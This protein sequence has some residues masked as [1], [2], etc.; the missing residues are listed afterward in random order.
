MQPDTSRADSH[1]WAGNY[2]YTASQI[3][4]PKTVEE[5]QA[6]VVESRSLRALGSR[7]SF[8]DVADNSD[9]LISLRH[10]DQIHA[11][12]T[13]RKTVTVGAGVTYGQL[14][15][16][17]DQHGFALHNLA[18]LPHI[19]VVGACMTATH[20]SGERNGNLATAV[21]GLE[22]VAADGRLVHLTR[23]QN[24]A[25]LDGLI[26]G[27]GA[28][29]IITKITLEVQPRFDMTQTIYLNL[30][31]EQA[32]AHF[33]AIQAS[34][35]S[36]SLFTQWQNAQFEQVW[37]KRLADANPAPATATGLFGA[38]PSGSPM[39]PV[40]DVDPT[41]CTGQL[42]VVGTWYERLPHFR[43]EFTPSHGAELQSEFFVPRAKAGEA[44]EAVSKLG[45]LIAPLLYISEIRTIAADQLWLSPCYQRDSV[46]IH[47]TWKPL[48][49]EV[50]QVLPQIEKILMPF[51]ARPHWGKL[52]LLPA[53]HIRTQYAR[54]AQF[55]ELVQKYDPEGKFR[56]RFLNAYI[57]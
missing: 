48:W 14:C 22:F 37:V 44:L 21:R 11:L 9:T 43:M 17:L 33:D 19:S 45:A 30:P 49:A 28:Y 10:L 24:S 31:F 1:N 8:N 16:Y 50:Q 3:L 5:I 23:E 38:I 15:T 42:G 13:Q 56:N 52:F 57:F 34:G 27:L 54:L 51:E 2:T 29:G 41:A 55:R 32:I 39:H 53:E 47:F 46:A 20:G 36:V 18:S 35:Y 6:A 26:V 25:E 12:D 40:P 4:Y 7:H